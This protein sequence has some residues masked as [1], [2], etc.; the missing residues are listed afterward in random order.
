MCPALTTIIWCDLRVDLG[1]GHRD[2]PPADASI[3]E[4]AVDPSHDLAGPDPAAHQVP[5]LRADAGDHERGRHPLAGDVT[6][7]DGPSRGLVRWLVSPA[8]PRCSRRGRRRPRASAS[9]TPRTRIR[10][11]RADRG[12]RATTG[13]REPPPTTPALSVASGSRRPRPPARPGRPAGRGPRP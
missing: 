7:R 9:N 2:E 3:A 12:A 8:R 4:M 6:D 5:Y 1:H 13:S 10:R 11:P